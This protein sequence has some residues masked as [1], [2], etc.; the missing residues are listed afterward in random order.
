MIFILSVLV[1]RETYEPVLLQRRVNQ[2]R[3]ETGIPGL[4]SALNL[5][6]PPREIL[7]RAI[8]RP[9]RMLLFSPTVT[10]VSVYM[11]VV[12][13]YLY[14]LFATF[15][16]VF[17]SQYGFSQDT[18]GLAYLGIGVGSLIGLCCFATVSDRLVIFLSKGREMKAEHRL[19]PWIF[20]S[21]CI[22]IGLFWYGW[23]AQN[24]LP[25]IMPIVG[26]G[27]VGF[28][29]VATFL[30]IQT[31][32][33][34]AFNRQAASALAANMVLRSLVGAFLP[35]A[36]PSMYASLGLGW[37]NSLL[38]FIALAMAPVSWLLFRH[39]ER[40]RGRSTVS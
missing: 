35:L 19:C 15:T 37:G 40:I 16:L 8:T 25:W 7:L 6:I 27:W 18:V 9:S 34:D 4:Q 1:L 11:A 38:A 12:F 32:L 36:G 28:G 29:M 30:S 17:Q 14:L 23:S 26:T 5:G 39:G 10:L 31:Y 21:L 22:P 13:G 20:G 24:K 33:I 3:R 2:L